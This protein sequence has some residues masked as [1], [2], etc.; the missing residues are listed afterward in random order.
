[1]HGG[2]RVRSRSLQI[3]KSDEVGNWP[4][5]FEVTGLPAQAKR[6]AYY[7]LWLTKGHKPAEP[8]GTF[9]VHASTTTVRFTSRTRSETSTGLGRDRAVTHGR[10]PGYDVLTT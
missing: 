4:M 3:A 8:C 6:G 9:R 5:Q 7:E 1:M 2:Q 10:A